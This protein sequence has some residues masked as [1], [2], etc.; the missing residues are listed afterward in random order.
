MVLESISQ[1]QITY[2]DLNVVHNIGYTTYMAMHHSMLTTDDYIN[3]EE[4]MT[5]I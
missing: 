3:L 1:L 2:A 5:L 4:L